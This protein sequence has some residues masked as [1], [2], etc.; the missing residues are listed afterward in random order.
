MSL[1]FHTLGLHE[2]GEGS[3]EKPKGNKIYST[4][5][6]DQQMVQFFK[7]KSKD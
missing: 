2:A 1:E 7:Q 6:Y 4:Y 5:F 3:R